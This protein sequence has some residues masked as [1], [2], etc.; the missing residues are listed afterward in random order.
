MSINPIYHQSGQRMEEELNWIRKAQSDPAFFG[1]IYT[2]YHEQIFRYV[3][4]RMDDE[5][6]AFDVT[7]QV[8]V[9]ALFN[10]KK[11]EFRGVPFSSWLYRIAKSELYQSFRDRKAERTVNIDSFQLHEIILEMEED[12]SE[13]NR[14]KL[15]QSLSKLK[16][17]DLQLIELRFFEKR[18]FKEIGEILEITENNAKVKAFRAIEK[19]KTIFNS[20]S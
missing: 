8:F 11:Y 2:K 12:Q 10:L 4:Q 20:K 9:K 14:Q 17:K 5:E 13:E 19:L 15:F 16:E 6:Q 7:S 1:P 18:S 3:Y